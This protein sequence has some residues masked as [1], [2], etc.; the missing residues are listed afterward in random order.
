MCPTKTSKKHA[1]FTRYEHNLW[2]PSVAFCSDSKL[3][4]C[5]FKYIHKIE[6]A[7]LSPLC[8]PT[9]LSISCITCLRLI[10]L[11]RQTTALFLSMMKLPKITVWIPTKYCTMIWFRSYPQFKL[12]FVVFN[13]SLNYSSCILF[14]SPPSLLN[15][16][17]SFMTSVRF[18]YGWKLFQLMVHSWC[19]VVGAFLSSRTGTN[20][21]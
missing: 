13:K 14:T 15:V 8:V 9:A 18:Y 1:C 5:Y 20:H 6:W 16:V 21:S 2:I 11:F 10:S 3:Y 12:C 17:V 7:L 19:R 4:S